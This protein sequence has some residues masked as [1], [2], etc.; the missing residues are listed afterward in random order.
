MKKVFRIDGK[1]KPDIDIYVADT[2]LGRLK[3]LLG[4]KTLPEH[5]GLLLM[6]CN[7][8]HMFFMKYPIDVVYVDGDYRI[9]KLV[10][11][12]QPWKI[13]LCLKSLH[14]IEFSVGTIQAYNY[15]PGKQFTLIPYK[16]NGVGHLYKNR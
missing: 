13:S 9:V 14:T 1:G 16:N 12:L 10:E 11:N 8:I 6:N 5:T 3:G 2:F 15:K 4:T 7:S